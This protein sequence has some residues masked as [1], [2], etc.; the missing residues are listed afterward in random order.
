MR[1]L[2]VALLAATLLLGACTGGS[3]GAGPAPS[4]GPYLRGSGTL[5]VPAG[6]ELAA[7]QPILDQARQATGVEVKLQAT[8]TLDGVENVVSGNAAKSYDTIW[9]ASN[10]YLQLHPGAGDKIGT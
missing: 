2:G 6:S 7:L 4:E 9:F 3:K 10:R 1:Q 8:G 5:R